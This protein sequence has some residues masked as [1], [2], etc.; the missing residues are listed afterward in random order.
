MASTLDNARLSF[1]ADF[2]RI[3]ADVWRG[4][5][6]ANGMS[7]SKLATP[8]INP[9]Q[10]QD[11][12]SLLPIRDLALRELIRHA[13]AGK[14]I[15]QIP[16][17]EAEKRIGPLSIAIPAQTKAVIEMAIDNGNIIFDAA[18]GQLKPHLQL[19]LG[20][21]FREL[22]VDDS[23]DIIV[24]I[25]NFP[26][27][28]LSWLSLGGL[29]VPKTLDELLALVFP[30]NE[31]EVE[32]RASA[33]LDYIDLDK[34]F[35]SARDI[36]PRPTPFSLGDLGVMPLSPN[37]K[38]NIDF[39]TSKLSLDG[40]VQVDGAH[41]QSQHL[42]LDGLRGIGTTEFEILNRQDLQSIHLLVNAS[43]GAIEQCQFKQKDGT[44]LDI[45]ETMIRDGRL[46]VSKGFEQSFADM[47]W[48]FGAKHVAG[49]VNGGNVIFRIGETPHA[50]KINSVNYSGRT[51]LSHHHYLID[52][53]L[54][55]ASLTMEHLMLDLGIAWLSLRN[56]TA[57]GSGR[58]NSATNC[59]GAFSG[60]WTLSGDVYEGQFRIGDFRA[61]ISKPTRVI[62]EVQELAFSDQG[63][64]ILNA[65]GVLEVSL[66][67]GRIPLGR[68]GEVRFSRGGHGKIYF[69]E[70]AFTDQ[71]A[72]PQIKGHF[73]I[74]A[75]ADS[76][77]FDGL[78]Q[79]PQGIAKL[80]TEE[81]SVSSSG[82]IT[83]RNLQAWVESDSPD[84]TS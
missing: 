21:V 73:D 49:T 52:G 40:F 84:P 82:E 7:E 31:T 3:P 54:D 64:E 11:A 48:N 36:S 20:F 17:R 67:S 83:F 79:L 60:K 42:A 41:L 14:I 27:L 69:S 19:P 32:P 25:E 9:P 38:L 47:Q 5:L 76:V 44:Q 6:L 37:T 53:T 51:E 24:D 26:D 13:N 81:F 2:L 61:G 46:Q 4:R 68:K 18:K 35:V 33:N 1:R 58:L 45:G 71:G 63:I 12:A 66:E 56:V 50:L 62:L 8:N 65:Q 74:T 16:L 75:N 10:I 30:E 29:R 77:D 15:A 28:N 39:Q 59:G 57:S 22:Y 80:T 78:V 23:G 34:L 72:Y 70:I 43:E 55:H